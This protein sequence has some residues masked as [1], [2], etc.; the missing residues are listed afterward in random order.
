MDLLILCFLLPIFLTSTTAFTPNTSYFLDCGSAHGHTIA[1]DTPPRDF[2]P[3]SPFLSDSAKSSS[4][5]NPS[6]AP[7]SPLYLTARLFYG[8]ASYGLTL[9]S[10]GTHI[11]RLHFLPFSNRHYNLSAARFDVIALKRFVL[12]DDFSTSSSTA[13]TIKEYFLWVDSGELDVTFVP[14]SS[15]PLAFVNAIEVFTAPAYLIKDEDKLKDIGQVTHQALETVHRINVGGLE[16]TPVND[17][18][19]RTW[20]PDDDYLPYKE[21]SLVNST[22][23]D[24]IKYKVDDTA[25]VAPRTVYST[26]R[27]MNIPSSMRDGNPDYNFNVTWSFPIRSS[28]HTDSPSEAFYMDFDAEGPS[29]GTINISIGRSFKSSPWD[30]N[31]I[32]NGLEI[33]KV[34]DTF[35]SLDGIPNHSLNSSRPKQSGV[36]VA[37]VVLAV[38]GGLVL[39]SLVYNLDLHI[40]LIDIKASTDGF[41]ESLV[42]GSGGFGKVY[43][44]VLADGT[45][46]AVK[47]A[48]PGSK[49]GYPEFQ[50]EILVLSKIRHRHLVS[51]IGYCEEQ[52]ER[53]LVY[54]Y[55]EKGP[56]R[57]YLGLHYLHTSQSH[58]II[59][60][61]I[62]STNILLDDNYLAKVSDFGL[63]KL[64][65]S[66]GETHVLCARAVI[67]RSLSTEQVNLAEWALQWQR[68]G[69]LEKII[70]HRL[71][72]N[73]NRNSLRKFGETAEKCVADYGDDRPTFADVLW[74]LEYALQLHVT[75]LK[76]EPHED[77]GNVELLIP[78]AATR[79]VE[80]TSLNVKPE[81]DMA[82]T[83]MGQTDS[84]DS[85][86]FSQ[87]ITSEGR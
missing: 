60:R 83:G 76:R 29:S 9:D 58:T 73:I 84:T 41:D 23:P 55:M 8:S 31:A 21:T 47:R 48:M 5:T 30:A 61:D 86:V 44:G 63:S 53:I 75:E 13:P 33:F 35:G 22:D 24:G 19:W 17:T 56:L 6:A 71:V 15:S 77:S 36:A 34:N 1:T 81:D 78:A 69:Q 65:P 46:V 79:G 59:H 37:A 87:L 68:K 67:D 2:V 85:T 80:S 32:L 4:V 28:F 66:C 26:A 3:D 42:V 74:N 64:R 50:T 70:D 38:V 49:Q 62:K 82:G 7:S 20:I 12:L 18:L 43:K 39:P 16:V 27:T 52:S 10:S 54:E 25:E 11:L 14:S 57:P 45:K 72:G 40:P 51:L